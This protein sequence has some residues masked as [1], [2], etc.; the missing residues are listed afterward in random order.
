MTTSTISDWFWSWLAPRTEPV[1]HRWLIKWSRRATVIMSLV[2]IAI[3]GSMLLTGMSEQL[4]CGV[5]GILMGII[6]IPTVLLWWAEAHTWF[7]ILMVR[8]GRAPKQLLPPLPKR[9]QDE[10]GETD[11]WKASEGSK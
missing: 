2:A 10:V 11:I 8:H 7:W 9:Y 6:M 1:D 4:I 5:A 3:T